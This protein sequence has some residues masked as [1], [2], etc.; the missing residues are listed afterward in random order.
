MTSRKSSQCICFC[1]RLI[2]VLAEASNPA[3]LLRTKRLRNAQGQLP[4]SALKQLQDKTDFTVNCRLNT[5]THLVLTDITVLQIHG[6]TFL[7]LS[8]VSDYTANCSPPC[9][10]TCNL[11]MFKKDKSCEKGE[12]VGVSECSSRDTA[13]LGSVD[14][15]HISFQAHLSYILGTSFPHLPGGAEA[16]NL[17][18]NSPTRTCPQ[19]RLSGAEG[20]LE[21]EMAPGTCMRCPG[22]TILHPPV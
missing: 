9:L 7:N 6:Q 12:H 8:P 14:P 11:C 13:K 22:A 17:Q 19:F 21:P 4:K 3:I 10:F 16:H 1:Q 20:C 18:S 5:V 15:F 2:R